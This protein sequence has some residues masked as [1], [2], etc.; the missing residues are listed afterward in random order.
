MDDIKQ[1][2]LI[3]MWQDIERWLAKLPHT[4]EDE[5][6]LKK[7]WQAYGRKRRAPAGNVHSVAAALLWVYARVNFLWDVQSKE[8]QQQHIAEIAGVSK[9]TLGQKAMA[10]I[11]SM[12][13][14]PMDLRYARQDIAEKNPF[15]Q[16]RLDPRTGFLFMASDPLGQEFGIPLVKQKQD[17][18]YDA[19]DYLAEGDSDKAVRLLRKALELD[20]HYVE[21][22]VGLV[23]TFHYKGNER[24]VEEYTQRGFAETKRAFPVWPTE[25]LW[26]EIENRQHL[27][28][29]YYQAVVYWSHNQQTQAEQL[30]KLLI[31]LNPNDNQGIRYALAAFY[32]GI[33]EHQLEMMWDSGNKTQNWDTLEELLEKQNAVH[34]FWKEPQYV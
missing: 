16:I 26:D 31:K 4:P 2:Y 17:Y 30:L 11:K 19:M 3:I 32:E 33:S 7:L 6:K 14:E 29:I 21:A 20:E 18:Y 1:E 23:A 10:I 8:W 5:E 22:Y 25:L 9:S 13:I 24:K 34:H 12:K 15:A 27:R 28:M